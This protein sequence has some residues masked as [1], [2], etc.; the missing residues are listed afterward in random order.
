M[1]KFTSYLVGATIAALTLSACASPAATVGPSEPP[2]AAAA[3]DTF[4][5]NGL[6]ISREDLE[7]QVPL[8]AID[9]H[10]RTA[11]AEAVWDDGSP[12]ELPPDE[13]WYVVMS[14]EDLVGVMRDIDVVVDPV[15][16]AVFPDRDVRIAEWVE[17]AT[18]LDPG[19]YVNQSGPCALTIDLGELTVPSIELQSP[20]DRASADLHLLVTE[21]SCNSGQDA[22]GRVEVVSLNETDDRVSLVIGVRPR[23]GSQSCPS[24]PATPFTVTLSEPVGEREVV[25]A[26]LADPRVLTVNG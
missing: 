6:S 7:A 24:N 1:K 2:T 5:C 16:G 12:L 26:N 15:S 17:D 19:W 23:N 21:Q 3:E 10:G 25:D 22:G 20:P 18:N 4:L 11:L 14:T 8:S 9:E 13:G